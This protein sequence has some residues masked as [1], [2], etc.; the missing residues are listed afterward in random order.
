MR[1]GERETKREEDI[2]WIL[3]W[4]M[5][6]TVRSRKVAASDEIHINS[7]RARA[8]ASPGNP[9]RLA[10]VLLCLNPEDISPSACALSYRSNIDSPFAPFELLLIDCF[11]A[12]QT[13]LWF[14][15]PSSAVT[16]VVCPNASNE[17]G[18]SYIRVGAAVDANPLHQHGVCLQL[19]GKKNKEVGSEEE[20]ASN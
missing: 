18:V 11:K 12:A 20:E 3:R 2:C 13:P 1:E 8:A 4:K 15:S 16:T 6:W 10:S 9:V 7:H 5:K 17:G 19:G 14:S